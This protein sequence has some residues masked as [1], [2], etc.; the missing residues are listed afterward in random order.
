MSTLLQIILATG[1]ISLGALVGVF[2][3]SLNQRTL[4]RWLINL[5]ALSA[6]TLLGGAM[7]HLLPE[8]VEELDGQTPFVIAT[9]AFIG[10]FIVE[11]LLR[12]RHCHDE[13]HTEKHTIGIMNLLG[14][15][16]HNFL[17]GVVIAGAFMTS[18]GLGIATTT[19]VALHEIPQEI[20]DF[21]V[22]LHSGFK[23]TKALLLNF[24][25]ALSVIFGGVIGYLM[26]NVIEGFTP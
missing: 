2:T 25:V 18:P 19:A 24:F 16:F 1:L 4:Q 20:G 12:W 5:V 8:A 23:R 13:E 6:G 15:F 3:I 17:D 11:K 22:L 26:S 21:G 14:D 9:F 10:F 7:L